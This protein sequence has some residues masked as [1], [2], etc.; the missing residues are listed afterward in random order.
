M[1]SCATC[2]A[3]HR[4]VTGMTTMEWLTVWALVIS[5][6]TLLTYLGQLT[7]LILV[8]RRVIKETDRN[9]EVRK[10]EIEKAGKIIRKMCNDTKLLLKITAKKNTVSMSMIGICLAAMHRANRAVVHKFEKK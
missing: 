8:Y 1:R 9:A 10:Q 5:G 3:T 4:G 7:V 2:A 6:A